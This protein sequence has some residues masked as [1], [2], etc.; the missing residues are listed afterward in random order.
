M[1]R[2]VLIK[3]LV[4]SHNYNLNDETSDKD[5]KIFVAPTFDDLYENKMFSSSKIG[6]A[7]DYDIHDIRKLSELLWKSNINFVEVLYSN[8]LLT[9]EISIKTTFEETELIS[10][11]NELLRKIFYMR[12]EIVTMNLPY[13]YSACKG[14]HFNKMSLLDKGTEGTMHLVE[15]YGYDTKQALHAYR[16]LDFII[17]FAETEFT[18]FKFAMTYSDYDAT[19]E[20]LL[21]L[22]H[23]KYTKDQ[24]VEIV[25]DR[26]KQ[27]EGYEEIYKSQRIKPEIKEKLTEII[28]QIVKINI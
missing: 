26:F 11:T 5:Y 17:R 21:D 28:K 3:A 2:K 10:K 9:Q 15:K 14:M 16:V 25:N 27:F 24:F 12:D 22:K 8:E 18:D 6:K 20:F 7:E 19:R 1:E 23:G 4:G 13:L